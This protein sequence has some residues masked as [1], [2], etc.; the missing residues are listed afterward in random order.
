MGFENKLNPPRLRFPEAGVQEAVE[1]TM[2]GRW[3]SFLY[4]IDS[5]KN[6]SR[7]LLRQGVTVHFQKTITHSEKRQSVTTPLGGEGL[8]ELLKPF[9]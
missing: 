5:N 7:A 6:W 1:N 3:G 8:A 2:R 4:G 9:C